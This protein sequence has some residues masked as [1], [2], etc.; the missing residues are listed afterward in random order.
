MVNITE[1]SVI[2]PLARSA[3]G[4]SCKKPD[5]NEYWTKIEKIV[6]TVMTAQACTAKE[7]DDCFL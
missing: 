5:F 4:F 6:Q 7:W 3:P 1:N 2:K